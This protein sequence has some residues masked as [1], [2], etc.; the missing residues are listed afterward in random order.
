VSFIEEDLKTPLC[1]KCCF[2]DESKLREM[3]QCSGAFKDQEHRMVLE[4]ANQNGRGGTHL[5][6]TNEQYNKRR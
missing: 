4:M 6:L 3:V 1:R 5:K 2:Q